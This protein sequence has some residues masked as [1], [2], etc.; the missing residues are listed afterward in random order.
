MNPDQ[1]LIDGFLEDAEGAIARGAMTQAKA[2][3][4]GILGIDDTNLTALSQLAAM[5]FADEDHATALVLF[6]AAAEHHSREADVYH[7]LAA[8]YQQLGNTENALAAL[9]TALRIDAGHEPALYDKARLLQTQ[10]RLDQAEKLYL[11]LTSSNR[12]R[13]DAIFNRG[14]VMFRKGNLIAADRW[15]RQAAKRD[16]KSPWPLINLAL[17]YRYWERFDDARRCLDLVIE[18][19]PDVAE[20]HWNLANLDLI[21]GKF[22]DGFA[23]AEWRFKRRGFAPPLRDLPKWDGQMAT[24]R[25]VLLVAEQGL[26]DTLQFVRYAT[27]LADAG[28]TVGVEA[29]PSLAGVLATVPGVSEVVVPGSDTA[30]YDSW[31]PLLSLPAV[32]GTTLATIPAEVPYVSVPDGAG[33]QKVPQ[34]GARVGVVWRGNPKHDSDMFRSIPLGHWQPVLATPGVAFVSLQMGLDGS[35]LAA[36]QKEYP[37]HDASPQIK[38]F[39]DTAATV[40]QLDLVITV[41]TAVA[42]LAAAMNKPVWLLISAANDWRWMAQRLDSPWYPSMRLF[43]ARRVRVWKDVMTAVAEALAEQVSKQSEHPQGSETV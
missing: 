10:G 38:D 40:A 7:G 15:F 4:Q 32:M 22:E 9:D 13:V 28:M 25:S 43:R 20:A 5:A 12:S 31:L 29:Q 39:A 18:R 1:D 35:E 21:E 37:I 26:G 42:H 33:P 41:D 17:I 19:D 2:L 24:G 30:A 34:D 27:R 36:F 11:Q 16:P 23:R 3:Y 14:V 6:A 8:V